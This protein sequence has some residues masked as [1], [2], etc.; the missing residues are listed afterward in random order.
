MLPHSCHFSNLI[1]LPETSRVARALGSGCLE[2]IPALRFPSC[3]TL[4]KFLNL[5]ELL[6]FSRKMDTMTK[7]PEKPFKVA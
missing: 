7:T 5:S 1:L 3:V 4:C 2:G 6:F